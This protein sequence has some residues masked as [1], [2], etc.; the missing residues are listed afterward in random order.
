MSKPKQILTETLLVENEEFRKLYEE[1]IQYEQDL[2]ALYSLK[3]FPPEVELRIKELKIVKLHGKDRM[4]Q[5]MTD[6]NNK[7]RD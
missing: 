4:R 7:K 6:Y 5:L 1:H 2:E 3:F